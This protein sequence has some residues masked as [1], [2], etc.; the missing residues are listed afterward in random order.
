MLISKEQE[1]FIKDFV[2]VYSSF[3]LEGANKPYDYFKYLGKGKKI[4]P[5]QIDVEDIAINSVFPKAT[6]DTPCQGIT[7]KHI[8]WKAGRLRYSVNGKFP[9]KYEK[10]IRIRDK[11]YAWD[12]CNGYGNHIDTIEEYIDAINNDCSVS[13][14]LLKNIKGHEVYSQ[15]KKAY[16]DLLDL[17]K[18]NIE[19][20]VK[21]FGPVYILT[22]I[23]FLSKGKFPI[24]DQFAHKAAKALYFNAKPDEV[25]ILSESDKTKVESVLRMYNEYCWLLTQIF[26]KYSIERD[27]DQ[28]LWVYGHSMTKYPEQ[29]QPLWRYDH[30][31]NKSTEYKEYKLFDFDCVPE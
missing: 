15:L 31:E 17:Q 8:A 21:Y 28:A 29:H 23:Y 30:S 19:Q 9:E 2:K 11:H 14:G 24:Y 20:K 22:L 7:W 6:L 10:T 16:T 12:G 5:T 4:T 18:Q 3:Y 25:F 1:V 27:E 26:G 13:S